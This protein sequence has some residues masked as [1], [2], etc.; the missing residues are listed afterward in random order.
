VLLEMIGEL[1][2]TSRGPGW[3]GVPNDR[4]HDAP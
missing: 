3:S 4:N 2:E 1:T